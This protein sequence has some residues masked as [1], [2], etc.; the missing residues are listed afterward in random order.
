MKLIAP[1][2]ERVGQPGPDTAPF[3]VLTRTGGYHSPNAARCWTY[4]TGVILNLAL[5]RDIPEH[6]V[7]PCMCSVTCHT[8][9]GIISFLNFD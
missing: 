2:S 5:P 1:G 7:S 6:R 9:L 8:V 4:I 3:S